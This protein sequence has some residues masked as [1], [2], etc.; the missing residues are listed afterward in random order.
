MTDS[1]LD[2]EKRLDELLGA[3][4]RDVE[5]GRDLWPSIAAQLENLPARSRRRWLP[6]LAAAVLLVA[7]SS[8]LTAGLL[9]RRDP[10]ASAPPVVVVEDPTAS[11]PP[12]VVVEDPTPMPAGF[13]PGQVLDA[14]YLAARQQLADLLAQRIDTLPASARSKLEGNLAE[15]HRA[16]AEINAAL[17]LQPGDPLLEELLLTTYQAELSVLANVNQLTRTNAAAGNSDS[18]RIEL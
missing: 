14:G 12:V 8:L 11:A 6:Q 3:L 7:C 9:Q 13:G 18:K 2:D 10:T 16:A 5:P 1:R 17:E 15:M 4:P